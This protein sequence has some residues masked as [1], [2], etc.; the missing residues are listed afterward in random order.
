M[1]FILAI[2]VAL[3]SACGADGPPERPTKS[4]VSLSGEARVGVVSN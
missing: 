1:R 4:G 3:L 2:T